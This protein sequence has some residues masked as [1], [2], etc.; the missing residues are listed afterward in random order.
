MAFIIIVSTGDVPMRC[1][2][3]CR[4]EVLEGFSF[5]CFLFHLNNIRMR[6]GIPS[7]VPLHPLYEY[8][9]YRAWTYPVSL[10]LIS[11]LQP[12]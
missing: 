11:L 7:V 6:C 10:T 12:G 4:P 3:F 8:N 2:A 9:V 1:E 5:P